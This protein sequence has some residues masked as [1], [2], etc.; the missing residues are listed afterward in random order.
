MNPLKKRLRRTYLNAKLKWSGKQKD[1]YDFAE[2]IKMIRRILVL[3]PEDKSLRPAAESFLK[4]LAGLFH[5]VQFETFVKSQLTEKDL[6]WFG[7]PDQA[8]LNH[9]QQKQYGLLIDLNPSP[10][11]LYSYLT[12]NSGAPVRLN[13]CESPYDY[14]Y[15][16][17]I[18][19]N[20][21][22]PFAGQLDTVLVHLHN[23]KNN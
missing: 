2:Q 12:A 22:K 7:V 3:M 23:L 1:M 15:N 17:H 19:P 21:S 11:Q 5:G 18:R 13:L 9:L 6:N 8:F 16:L 4:K 14:I 10:D 20:R